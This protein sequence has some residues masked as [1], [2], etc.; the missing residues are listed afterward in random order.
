MGLVRRK[1][2]TTRNRTTRTKKFIYALESGDLTSFDVRVMQEYKA[3][4]DFLPREVI[5]DF[6]REHEIADVEYIH[7]YYLCG[8]V[9]EDARKKN[10]SDDAIHSPARK[11]IQKGAFS[12]VK[13]YSPV[14]LAAT[15]QEIKNANL[16]IEQEQDKKEAC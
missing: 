13:L 2:T 11:R 10:L 4:K 5:N 16:V 8:V 12:P 15:Y 3:Y 7:F 9:N 1:A 14:F 6:M